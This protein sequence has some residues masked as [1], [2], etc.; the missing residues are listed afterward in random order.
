MPEFV[1][2]NQKHYG[3]GFKPKT[4]ASCFMISEDEDV[5]SQVI[6]EIGDSTIDELLE[7][8]LGEDNSRPT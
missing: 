3:L 2:N 4:Y 1:R 6:P 5:D 8:Y 7:V